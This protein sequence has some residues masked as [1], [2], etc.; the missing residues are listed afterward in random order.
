MILR[1]WKALPSEM[2]CE[3][4]K[5]Y[6]DILKRKKGSL[7][8]KRVFDFLLSSLLIVVLFPLFL[9]LA[10][11]IKIDSRGPVF[12]R[13][14]R[15]TRYGETFR[16]FKFRTMV[17]DAEKTG[18][19]VTVKN[20]ARITR[21]GKFVRKYR[22]DEVCQLLDVWRGKM[23]FVGTRPE[24]E[25]YVAHYTPEMRATLL[26]PAGITSEASIYYRDESALLDG[27]NGDTENIYL[28][29]ILPE[30]MKYNLRAVERFSLFREWGI[31]IK[32]VLAVCGKNCRDNDRQER[33]TM[34]V[35]KEQKIDKK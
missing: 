13:Q 26:L 10:V 9:C 32:T 2:Q 35:E 34:T 7:F 29:K 20:D 31:M 8:F 25:K 4:V 22:L 30:K 19:R 11:S 1:K 24:V 28:E 14:V 21:V 3:E 27:E 15:V 17:A 12:F 33:E 6:Y 18:P 23:T 5:K 16:I